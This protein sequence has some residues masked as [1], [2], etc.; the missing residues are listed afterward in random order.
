MAAICNA[1]GI[2]FTPCLLASQVVPQRMHTSVKAKIALALVPFLR[3]V[4]GFSTDKLLIASVDCDKVLLK[5]KNAI[6]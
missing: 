6:N 4:R 3:M 2:Y 1:S 5:S